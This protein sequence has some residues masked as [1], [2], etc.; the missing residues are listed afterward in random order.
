MAA[1]IESITRQIIDDPR[2][3]A[4][5]ARGERPVFSAQSDAAITIVGQSPSLDAQ[6]SG[7]CWDD[8]SGDTL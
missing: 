7:L 8:R 6:R 5:T 1:T 2:D 3:A 4:F